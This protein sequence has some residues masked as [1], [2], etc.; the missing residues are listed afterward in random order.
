MQASQRLL[1]ALSKRIFM[2]SGLAAAAMHKMRFESAFSG[3]F[4]HFQGNN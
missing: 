1:N 4:R 3:G 2:H